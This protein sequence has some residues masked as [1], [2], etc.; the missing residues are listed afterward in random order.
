MKYY[1]I[2][3]ELFG[4]PAYPGDPVPEKEEILAI[5]KGD[6]CNLTY[7]KMCAHNGTHM[8]A[9][10]HFSEGG[11]SIDRIRPEQF[12]G[13]CSV[14]EYDGLLDGEQ[15]LKL[16]EAERTKRRGLRK[17]LWKGQ[18]YFG[19]DAAEVFVRMGLELIG[20]ERQTVGPDDADTVQTH[21]VL[22]KAGIVLL[23]GLDLSETEPGWYFL[24]APPLKLAG[25]DG[26]PCRPILTQWEESDFKNT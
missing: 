10:K 23:E 19:K 24:S 12:M 4:T 13:E 26:A 25:C 3:R 20:V 18:T 7:L 5:R 22:L 9:P 21:Q 11:K 1:D 2:A 14:L 15:A 8:D 16:L 6:V 17:V